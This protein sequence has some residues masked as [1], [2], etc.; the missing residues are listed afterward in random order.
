MSMHGALTNLGYTEG[1]KCSDCHG[2][3]D[4]LPLNDPQFADGARQSRQD[5][6]GVPY[7]PGSESGEFRSACRPP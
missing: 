2:S 4:I 1:A 5:L 3:H 6:L 7:Q